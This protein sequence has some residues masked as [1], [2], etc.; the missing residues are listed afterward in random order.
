M[1]I[2][3]NVSQEWRKTKVVFASKADAVTQDQTIRDQS[4]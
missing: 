4:V 3:K 1:K 2:N